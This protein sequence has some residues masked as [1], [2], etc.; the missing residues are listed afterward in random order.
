MEGPGRFRSAGGLAIACTHDG[1]G[2]AVLGLRPE[3]VSVE[4]DG[5]ENS[6]VA[7]VEF[8]SYLGGLIDVH[9]RLSDSDRVIAQMVNSGGAE[10]PRVGERITVGWPAQAAFVFS[11][12]TAR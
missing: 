3:R 9:C 6:F 7:T 4:P 1:Q 12:E 8:V 10:L 11:G 5:A 2:E